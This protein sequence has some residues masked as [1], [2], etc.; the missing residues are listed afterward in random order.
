MY[1]YIYV[2][3]CIY[4]CIYM[5]IGLS[6]LQRVGENLEVGRENISYRILFIYKIFC[7]YF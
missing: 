6:I 7:I 1:I 2:Y 3:I 4:I 5:C